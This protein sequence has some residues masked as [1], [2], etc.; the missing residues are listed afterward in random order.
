MKNVLITGITGFV[1]AHLAKKLMN[2]Y[3]VVGIGQDMKPMTALSLLGIDKKVSYVNGDICNINLVR[4][5]LADYNIDIVYHLAAQAI[6]SIGKKDPM[7]TFNVN[8]M[9]TASIL[10][11]CRQLDNL[12]SIVVVST[13]KVYGE[14]LERKENDK[15]EPKGI[16]EISKLAGEIIGRGFY[17]NYNLPIVITRACNIYGECDLNRR[18]IPNTIIDLKNN[19]PPLI[20]KNDESLR[21]YIYVDDVVDAYLMLGNIIDKTKGEVFNIGSGET[22]GQ[23]ELVKKIIKISG[24]NIEPIYKEK[25]KVF[26]EIYQQNINSEKIRSLLGWK[27]KYNLE[28]GL[29]RTWNN[30]K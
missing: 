15:L 17:Y 13:D 29:K 28:T 26:L 21:E 12:K 11:A 4:R 9:G 25:Q 14:G 16:Y 18:I 27:P 10:E 1:G 22:I 7:N 23:E 5:V 8:C 20:F 3:N 6:V 2:D 24:K 30:W 19:K